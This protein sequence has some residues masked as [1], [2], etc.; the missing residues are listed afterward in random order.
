MVFEAGADGMGIGRLAVPFAVSAVLH[1]SC[2]AMA[3]VAIFK[4][5][6][7]ANSLALVALVVALADHAWLIWL[8]VWPEALGAWELAF[9]LAFCYCLAA[10]VRAAL[11]RSR[12]A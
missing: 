10:W 4:K 3:T 7:L 12:P 2:V 8:G 11:R 9:E 6:R 5:G 1:L